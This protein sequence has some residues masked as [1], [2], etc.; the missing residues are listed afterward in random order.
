MK[1]K[2]VISKA[3]KLKLRKTPSRKRMGECRK[4]K[5]REGQGQSSGMGTLGTKEK[6]RAEKTHLACLYEVLVGK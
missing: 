3:S 5:K 4:R 2:R 1:K 6:A